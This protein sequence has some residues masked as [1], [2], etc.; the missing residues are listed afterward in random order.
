MR[1][2]LHAK[3]MPF[4]NPGGSFVLVGLAG[5][6]G[7]IAVPNTLERICRVQ[8]RSWIWEDCDPPGPHLQGGNNSFRPA[9]K[10][11]DHSV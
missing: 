4:A 10:H 2:C 11:G 5:L 8:I 3:M 9:R 7:L 1:P 6:V